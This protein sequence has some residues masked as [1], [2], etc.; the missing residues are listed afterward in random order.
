MSG[1]PLWLVG[2]GRLGEDHGGQV[3]GHGGTGAFREYFNTVLAL[4]L[5]WDPGAIYLVCLQEQLGSRSISQRL[6]RFSLSFN[7][8]IFQVT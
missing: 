7:S 6:F 2:H 4:L 1:V 3:R 5:H 8:Q